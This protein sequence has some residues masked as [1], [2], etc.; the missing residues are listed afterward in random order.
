MNR[1]SARIALV[2]AAISLP[3]LLAACGVRGPLSPPPA[4]KIVDA[5]G[6]EEEESTTA[7]GAVPVGPAAHP[8]RSGAG[9]T[10]PAVVNAPAASRRNPVLDWLV[11]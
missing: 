11:N 6:G 5:N 10:N 8:T 3:L 1:L 9:T 2:A 4:S 7:A